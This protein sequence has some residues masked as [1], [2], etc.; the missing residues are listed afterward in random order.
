MVFTQKAL[1]PGYRELAEDTFPA[2]IQIQQRPNSNKMVQ[3]SSLFRGSRAHSGYTWF[4]VVVGSLHR[5]IIYAR[6]DVE[7][8]AFKYAV[9]AVALLF[10]LCL[11]MGKKEPRDHRVEALELTS[12]TREVDLTSPLVK[13]K[14][15]MVVENKASKA[16]SSVYY[17]VERQLA[18]KLAY[19]D[20]QVKRFVLLFFKP[21]CKNL[22]FCRYKL[23]RT[24]CYQLLYSKT[25]LSPSKTM[26]LLSKSAFLRCLLELQSLWWWMS[27]SSMLL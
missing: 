22:L 2:Q 11:V 23:V 21:T 13:L 12:V 9:V 24:R 6:R 17:T 14:V 4:S 7:E 1:V 18:K 19:I 3:R 8:M 10:C 27:F 26:L 15:T 5:H 16:V 20:A 25:P